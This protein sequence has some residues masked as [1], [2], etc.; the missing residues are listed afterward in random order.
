GVT[1]AAHGNVTVNSNGTITYT[2]SSGY[3]GAD[4]F[5]YTIT[6]GHGHQ[7][8]ATVYV[9]V[10]LQTSVLVTN[11]SCIGTGSVALY[12]RLVQGTT[13]GKTNLL[14]GQTLLFLVNGVPIGSAVTDAYGKAAGTY[15]PT[16]P[17][18]FTLTVQYA[19]N[20][21]YAPSTG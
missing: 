18:S 14:A 17:G 13:A 9:N 12:A 1:P 10:A 19:G 16:V 6:D 11:A 15:L 7:S 8:T 4:T 21:T 20:S 3:L 5:T 2:P